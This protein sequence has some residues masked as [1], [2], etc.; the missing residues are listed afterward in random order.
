VDQLIIVTSL[1]LM[2]PPAVHGLEAFDEALAEGLWGRRFARLGEKLR[3]GVD[4]EH[5]AAFETS[6][7]RMLRLL[8]EI[9]SG[10]RG[11][12]PATVTYLSGDV[13]FSYLAEAHHSGMATGS[14]VL[15]AVCSPL[16]NPLGRNIRTM[17]RLAASRVGLA[18]GRFLTRRA[19]A[20]TL[21]WGWDI[22]KGP[23]FGNTLGELTVRGRSLEVTMSGAQPGPALVQSWD[24]DVEGDFVA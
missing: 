8:T 3:Q 1:P 15:Q 10:E 18:V 4:L 6:L 21:G 16:R 5:W 23:V 7:Q 2:L 11:S 14:R 12:P 19:H 22:T 20:T 13:H 17:E 24:A 9:V